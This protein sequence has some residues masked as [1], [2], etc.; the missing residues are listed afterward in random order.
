MTLSNSNLT[1][2]GS[3]KGKPDLVRLP[4]FV[5]IKIDLFR[6]CILQ[7]LPQNFEVTELSGQFRLGAMRR[8]LPTVAN[9]DGLLGSGPKQRAADAGIRKSTRKDM[10]VLE[11]LP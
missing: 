8:E 3:Q 1:V 11:S 9:V 4:V 6:H 2:E 10:E 7:Y 5:V